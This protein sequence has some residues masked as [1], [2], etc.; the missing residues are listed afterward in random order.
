MIGKKPV[1]TYYKSGVVN[2]LE[3]DDMS[4]HGRKVQHK[5]TGVI[6]TIYVVQLP[7]TPSS[8]AIKGLYNCLTHLL[9]DTFVLNNQFYNLID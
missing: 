2:T 4:Y 6:K 5:R 1:I 3:P 8:E 7:H 9:Y